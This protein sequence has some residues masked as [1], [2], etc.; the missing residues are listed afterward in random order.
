MLFSL[1]L[2]LTN[3][4]HN[5]SRLEFLSG[6]A[7]EPWKPR[8]ACQ[9]EVRELHQQAK[10]WAML[11]IQEVLKTIKKPAVEEG[12]VLLRAARIYGGAN[13]LQER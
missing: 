3:D 7:G 4:K 6:L 10:P 11:Q 1:E 8:I 13:F 5:V 9:D 2:M 12:S